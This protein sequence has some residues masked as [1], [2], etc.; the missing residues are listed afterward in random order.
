VIL[1]T[2]RAQ[3]KAEAFSGILSGIQSHCKTQAGKGQV[4]CY[5]CQSNEVRR[6]GFYRNRNFTVQR[7]K[8]SHCGKSFSE[9]TPLDGLRVPLDK[10]AQTVHL[11]CEGMGIRAIARFTSL[12]Q[13]TVLNVL[14][15]AGQK[16]A[17]LMDQQVRNVKADFVQADEL[18]SFVRKKQQFAGDDETCGNFYTHLAVCRDSKLI[19]NF[20]VSKRSRED[21]LAFMQDLKNRMAGRFMLTTDGLTTYVRKTGVVHEVFGN[22]IDYASEVKVFSKENPFSIWRGRLP[23][24]VRINRKARIGNPDLRMA[25]TCHVERMNLSVR[26]FNRR[27]TRCTLGFSKK[28]D[29]L[30]HAVALFVWHFDFV[31]KHSAH[32]KTPAMAANLTDHQWTVQEL[33]TATV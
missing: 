17:R 32:G 6:R 30:K 22:S 20:Q 4:T 1:S 31:R 33:L 14:E 3:P 26:L 7:F 28:L 19:V 16:A 29:N 10:A 15:L 23:A 13:E 11:L 24:V 12:D 27:F 25:T 9:K 18:L 21:S 8:C 5:C 2:G